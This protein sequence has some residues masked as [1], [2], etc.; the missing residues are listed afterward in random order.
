MDKKSFRLLPLTLSLALLNMPLAFA[1]E[2]VSPLPEK[3]DL[4]PAKVDLG[5][6]LFHDPRLSGNNTISCSS[7]HNLE[8]GG[9][10]QAP[11]STGINGQQGDIRAPSVYNSGFNFKQFWN[12]R[13]DTLQD[14]AMGPVTNPKEMG[15]Q[16]PEVIKKLKQ[17]P[18]YVKAFKK[19]YGQN[20]SV[21]NVVDAIAEF[22]HSLITPSRFDDY[23]RGDQNAIT[24]Q[25]KK[26]YELFK[27]YGCTACHNGVNVGGAM[28]QKMGLAKDYFKERGKPIKSADLGRFEVTKEEKDKFVFKVP[29]LRNITLMPPYYHD[30]SVK[31]LDEAIYKM[32]R[33]QLGVE[34]P[35]KDREDIAAFLKSLTGKQLEQQP[36][37]GKVTP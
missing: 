10:D 26:G 33:Y 1:Q 28:F 12:G 34:I 16:W 36:N 23:L 3:L 27:S 18:S 22:E 17:D 19:I 7:C 15:A 2:P 31:T 9:T 6:R 24:P 14:Q 21:S 11:V 4:N 35:Q 5:E 32:G 20:I 8:T 30:G 13:A 37:N 25:E 29:T